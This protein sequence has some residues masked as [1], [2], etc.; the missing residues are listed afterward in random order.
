[1]TTSGTTTYW[2]SIK[3]GQTVPLK[4]K[5]YRFNADGSLGAEVTSTVPFSIHVR[6]LLSCTAGTTDP[7]VLP[8]ATGGTS[9]RYADG[10]FIF[11]WDTPKPA[12]KCYQVWVSSEDGSVLDVTSTT[13]DV[14]KEA[15]FKSK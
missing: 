11:N 6:T 15:Y 7:D 13:G 12:G 5:A 4:F 9:F 2:N 8:A 10:Q 14:A 1:M 3:G